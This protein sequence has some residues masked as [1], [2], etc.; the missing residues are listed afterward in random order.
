M[1]KKCFVLGVVLMAIA[2]QAYSSSDESEDPIIVFPFVEENG[3]LDPK[4]KTNTP[5]QANAPEQEAPT[6]APV[7]ENGDPTTEI[8]E[9]TSGRIRKPV[10]KERMSRAE[11]KKLAEEQLALATEFVEYEE[12]ID[13]NS[14]SENR[15]SH[16]QLQTLPLITFAPVFVGNFFGGTSF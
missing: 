13:L 9:P 12:G 16:E 6:I 15:R 8:A 5:E 2:P 14:S 7:E 4:E 1:R 3:D 11:K 10:K